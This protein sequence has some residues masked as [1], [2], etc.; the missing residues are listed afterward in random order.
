MGGVRPQDAHPDRAD[1][2]WRGVG[3]GLLLHAVPGDRTVAPLG[4]AARPPLPPRVLG[5]PPRHRAARRLVPRPRPQPAQERRAALR[6]HHRRALQAAVQHSVSAS[7]AE[8]GLCNIFPD[9]THVA[10]S[11]AV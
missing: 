4:R 2:V 11:P 3:G 5:L 6:Q 8:E 9:L 1:C 10:A 7:I